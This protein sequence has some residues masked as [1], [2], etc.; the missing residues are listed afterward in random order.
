MY[1]K[2]FYCLICNLRHKYTKN[3]YKLQ[4]YLEKFFVF[5]FKMFK[6]KLSCV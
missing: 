2:R 5:L 3:L 6:L 4:K 1:F